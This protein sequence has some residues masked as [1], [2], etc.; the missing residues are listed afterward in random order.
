MKKTST[1]GIPANKIE[2]IP[3]YYDSYVEHVIHKNSSFVIPLVYLQEK[4]D[5]FFKP[6]IKMR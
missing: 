5:V 2:V 3:K 1:V 6:L 4:R